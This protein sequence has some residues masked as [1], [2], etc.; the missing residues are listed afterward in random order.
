[1]HVITRYLTIMYLA[2]FGF[3]L[4]C[5]AVFILSLDLATNAENIVARSDGGIAAVAKYAALRLPQ[6]ISETIKFA[7]LFAALLTLTSLMRHNQLAPIW[8]GGISQF[9]MIVRLAPVALAVG[10]FQFSI[11]EALVPHTNASLQEWGVV[12]LAPLGKRNANAATSAN[13]I[14]VNNDVA[15][16]PHVVMPKG[17]LSDFIIF[18]RNNAGRLVARLD[19]SGAQSEGVGWVLEGVT[20]RGIDG[21]IEK[22]DRI[23]G[24]GVDFK[25]KNLEELTIHPRDLSFRR[26]F[27]FV[28]AEA[29][30]S[31]APHLY[32][33]WLQVKVA[34]CFVP[35]LM[36]F[37]VVA[38][39]Q[40]FQ[41]TG[42]TEFLF[43]VGLALGFA[44]FIFNGIGLAMGEVGLLPPFLAGWAAIA[45]FTAIIGAI[46]FS[47]EVHDTAGR[48][49]STDVA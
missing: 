26:L 2:R 10:I 1:M 14:Q 15:R 5:I 28:R 9:G 24:W 38:L 37:L 27:S 45:G 47:R 13:W 29:H 40:K 42:R 35:L 11:D 25:P 48:D 4:I 44:F 12:E 22:V 20:R 16:I 6:I 43:L 36:L 3:L 23:N 31:W 30:G 18:Q 33:T 34:V 19:V 32:E 7:C 41:R 21:R 8:S 49:N 46:A 17:A 39:S